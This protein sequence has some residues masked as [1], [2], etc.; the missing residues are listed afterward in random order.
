VL[1]LKS[2][3]ISTDVTMGRAPQAVINYYSNNPS[4]K[5]ITAKKV[6]AA[7]A[8]SNTNAQSS[9]STADVVKSDCKRLK[10]MSKRLM[11]P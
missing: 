5:A 9:P 10:R 11:K 6:N 4:K 7:P 3:R 2:K 1:F 8:A